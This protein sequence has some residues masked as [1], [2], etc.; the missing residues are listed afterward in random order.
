MTIDVKKW[1]LFLLAIVLLDLCYRGI[2]Y[3][4]GIVLERGFYTQ[5]SYGVMYG[6]IFGTLLTS[7]DRD[8]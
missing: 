2:F 8:L 1:G 5:Y 7:M 6:I 3:Y 4:F